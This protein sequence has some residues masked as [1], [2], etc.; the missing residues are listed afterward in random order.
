MKGD[1]ERWGAVIKAANIPQA[2]SG[3]TSRSSSPTLACRFEATMDQQSTQ[4]SITEKDR[5]HFIPVRKID[6][7][8]AL[9]THGAL[10][11][12]RDKFR[13]LCHLLGAIEHYEYHEQLERLH[14]DY[15]YFAPESTAHAQA[16]QGT[17]K[18]AYRNLIEGL[19]EEFCTTQTSSRCRARRS[20]ARSAEDSIVRVKIRGAARQT[21][22]MCGSS[23]AA[24]TRNRG[25]SARWYGLRKREQQFKVYDDVVMVVA[26]SRRTRRRPKTA[27]E[28][29]AQ[30]A[31]PPGAVL[32]KYFRNIASA[33]LNAL[34]PDV[35]VVMG[36]RDQ[37]MLGVPA[38]IG[39]VPILLK[40]ASP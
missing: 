2:L 35:K 38:L 7:V 33:D 30:A 34:F 20:S 11:P 22:A 10:G 14:N 28:E 36:W 15:F 17:L 3:C 5:E 16:G 24:I 27:R 37:L 26:P 4:H 9:I 31:P 6:I 13:Q 12:D 29:V 18:R 19:T 25:E 40:L 23:A 8:E 39:G 32:L 1:T 21:I